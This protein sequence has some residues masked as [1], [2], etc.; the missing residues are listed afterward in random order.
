[1]SRILTVAQTAEKLQLS[2]EVIREYLRAGKIPG[3]KIGKSWRVVESDLENWVSVG[4]NEQPK[5]F[6]SARGFLKQFPG[7]LS[8]E[9][10]MA[11]KHAEIEE[12]ERR[13]E[14]RRKSKNGEAA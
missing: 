10:F 8:S 1:M 3:R 5:Q 11:E 7:K 12:E 14:A 13:Y 6:V 9:E 4:Q 2:E